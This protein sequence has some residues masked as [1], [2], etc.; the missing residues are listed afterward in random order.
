MTAPTLPPETDPGQPAQERPPAFPGP[1]ASPTGAPAIAGRCSSSGSWRRS[2][3]S[4]AASPPAG[5]TRPRRS[6]TTTGRSTRPP[7]PSSSTARRTARRRRSRRRPSSCSSSPT[8]TAPSTIRP[9]AAAITDMVGRL[10]ALEATVD[11][12]TGPVLE[13]ARRPDCTAPPE[14]GLVSP[15][16]TTVRIAAR[17]PGDGEVLVARLVPVPALIDEFKAEYP[18]YGIHPLNNTL[19][20]DEIQE[21]INGGLDASLRLTIPLTFLIL[22]IAFG[23]VV[24]AVVPLVLAVTALLAAFGMLGLYSQWV[25]AGQPVRQPA[26]RADRPRGRR[27]LLAVHADP[28]P[29]RAAARPVEARRDPRREQHGRA[30]GVLLRPRGGDLDRRAVPA[31]RPALPVDGDRDDLGRARRG[32]RLADVP[33][34]DARDPR[35]RREPA[36]DPVPRS[37]SRGGQR[38]LGRPRPGGHEGAAPRRDGLSAVLLLLLA[39]AAAPAPHG[40]GRLHAR[41][42]TRSTASRR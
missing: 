12:V 7:R 23:A 10:E 15:D 14:A 18:D 39:H 41:S 38:A 3:C 27:R 40:P 37:R 13:R 30:G 2:G 21:L 25:S 29:D 28:V 42:R 17:V 22:L 32:H 33:A 8:R 24:A 9:T 26:G 1:S 4:W 20:N 5:P 34:G 19:A 6:R 31:R 35:R 36:P 11:G 16:G